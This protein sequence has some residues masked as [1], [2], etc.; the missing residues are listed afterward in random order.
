LIGYQ[1]KKEV[2]GWSP[3][4]QNQSQTLWSLI[5]QK[6]HSKVKSNK[7]NKEDYRVFYLYPSDSDSGM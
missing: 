3:I 1:N 2:K 7:S 5:H 6:S 4:Y